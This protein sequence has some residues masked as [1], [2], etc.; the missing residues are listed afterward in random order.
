MKSK[1]WLPLLCWLFVACQSQTKETLTQVMSFNIRYDNSE[2]APH[3]WEARRDS[4]VNVIKK[5]DVDL[6]GMQEVLHH[7]LA[8]IKEQL[9]EYESVGVGRED[10]ETKGEYAPI[11]YKKAKYRAM[12]Q[13]YFWLS[14]T[15]E[16]AGKKGWDAACERIVTWVLLEEIA[17]KHSLLMMNT[18]FDHVGEEARRKSVDLLVA[19]AKELS[20]GGAVIITGDFNADP[21][22]EVITKMLDEK[23]VLPLFDTRLI[24]Q[25]VAG[26]SWTFHDFGQLPLEERPLIDY[27]FVN[28][29]WGVQKY[30]VIEDHSEVYLSDHVPVFTVLKRK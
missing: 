18:H 1:L 9:P 27:I 22:S 29:A 23:N 2:D 12:K 10:G 5:Y 13:G 26:T 8:Y 24:A 14:E 30:E 6:L 15:P 16:V 7:Q 4:V 25:S 21:K 17:T 3:H 20:E 28:E 11:L 19:K